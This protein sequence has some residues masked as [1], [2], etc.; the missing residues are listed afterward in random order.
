MSAIRVARAFTNAKVR[1][2]SSKLLYPGTQRDA[3]EMKRL[4]LQLKRWQGSD[5]EPQEIATPERIPCI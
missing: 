4:G 1:R 2:S 3:G 5:G